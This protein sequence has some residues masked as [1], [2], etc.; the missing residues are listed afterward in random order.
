MFKSSANYSKSVS[1]V[2][3]PSTSNLKTNVISC[4]GV[5]LDGKTLSYA[6]SM[7]SAYKMYA[8]D[9]FPNK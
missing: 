4:P 2:L 9:K 8:K 5:R 7:C 3:C 6:C 1:S